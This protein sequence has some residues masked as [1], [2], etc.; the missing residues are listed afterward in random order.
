LWRPESNQHAND[1]EE[2]IPMMA[3]MQQAGKLFQAAG[4]DDAVVGVL[5]A[6]AGYASEAN[7]AAEGPDRLIALGSRRHQYRAATTEPPRMRRR[8]GSGHGKRCGTDCALQKGSPYKRRDP[9]D[10]Q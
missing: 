5:L 6:D 1:S 8:K 10:L 2:F 7:L 3:A 9:V 4:R